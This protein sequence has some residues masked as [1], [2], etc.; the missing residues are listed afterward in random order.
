MNCAICGEPLPAS[1]RKPLKYHPGECAK[2][3]RLKRKKEAYWRDVEASRA[4]ARNWRKGL[5]Q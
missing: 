2:A 1:K 3:A 4:K 5:R